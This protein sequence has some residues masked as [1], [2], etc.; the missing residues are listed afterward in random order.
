MGKLEKEL[1]ARLTYHNLHHTLDVLQAAER[2]AVEE[3]IPENDKELLLTAA[4]FHDTGFLKKREGHEAESCNIAQYYLPSY[5]YTPAEIERVCSMIMATRIP[6]SPGDKMG[7]IL[8]DA[9]LDYLGRDDFFMLSARLFNEL[10]NEGL[11]KNE[12]EW[13]REQADFMGAHQYFSA[14]RVKLRQPVKA[15][16]IE[17]IKSK[18]TNQLFNEN[19]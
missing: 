12:E 2:I 19:Q 11:V 9:D 14:S 8:C 5:G 18:I 13:N 3:A 10:K 6:Q 4:L 16:Y 7:R 17:L 1:P 15:H